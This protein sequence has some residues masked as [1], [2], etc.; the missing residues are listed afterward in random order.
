MLKILAGR[1]EPDAGTLRRDLNQVA[2]LDQD[3]PAN[4]EGTVHDVI[5]GGARRLSR[6]STNIRI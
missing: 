1:L 3:V 2:Y 5:R 4:V 6:S